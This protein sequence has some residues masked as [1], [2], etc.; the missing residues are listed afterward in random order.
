MRLVNSASQIRARSVLRRAE[1]VQ[2]LTESLK[3]QVVE[4]DRKR[5][6]SETRLSVIQAGARQQLETRAARLENKLREL[7]ELSAEYTK[8]LD[9]ARADLEDAERRYGRKL[10][11]I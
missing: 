6:L 9:V 1:E 5:R 4:A 7:G 2:L 11:E 3:K 10:V 8:A